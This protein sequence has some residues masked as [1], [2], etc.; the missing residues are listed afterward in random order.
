MVAKA[1]EKFASMICAGAEAE[2]AVRRHRPLHPQ[3]S[4]DRHQHP[5]Q[6][7]PADD[8]RADHRVEHGLGRRPAGFAGLLR[9]RGG[10]V[11]AV[12]DEQ[13]HEHGRQERA[14]RDGNAA[15]VGHHVEALMVVEGQQ[16]Q[17]EHEHAEDLEDHPGVVDDGD[18]SHAVDV[19]HRDH[20][21]G[22][23]RDDE[24]GVQHG[25]GAARAEAVPAQAVQRGDQRQRQRRHHRG[26]GDDAGEQVDPA[27]EPG[28]GPVREVLR[29]LEHRAGHR[30]V[31]G[32]LREV[33]RD[34]EL[35]ERDHRPGPDEHPAQRGQ[36]ERE[37]GEDPGRR[38]DVA[39]RHRERA[40]E[41]ERAFQLLLVAV[42]GEVGGVLL[43]G[44]GM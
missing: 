36:A 31:A 34:D 8:E 1:G 16:H 11:E 32:D 35:A 21:Q 12:D 33:Q 26:D 37:Q 39:E 13:A 4:R 30:V 25:V 20:H 15:A 2:A 41:P 44:G 27:G 10:G 42:L 19:Q 28:V 6:E 38:R 3:V 40:A 22:D 5:Q 43:V 7:H 9:E 29:P 18:Q 17:R 23:Q 14:G 24:L